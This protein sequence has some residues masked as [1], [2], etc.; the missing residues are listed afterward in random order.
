[1][2]RPCRLAIISDIH[3]ASAAEQAR[4]PDYELRGIGNPLLRLF[5]K[6]HRRFFWMRAPLQQGY[7]LERFLGQAENFDYVIANGD[8][9]CNSAFIG[10]ADDAA[11]QSAADCLAK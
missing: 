11:F 8:Y 7:L 9:S 1:M 2:P 6:V 10:V 3:Y 4:G 5:V